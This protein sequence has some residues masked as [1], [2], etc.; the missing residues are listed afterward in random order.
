MDVQAIV[1]HAV[2]AVPRAREKNLVRKHGIGVSDEK[3]KEIEEFL[4]EVDGLS[5]LA[6]F[7]VDGID[8]ERA[9]F[10]HLDYRGGRALVG[11]RFF[12]ESPHAREQLI[13]VKGLVDIVVASGVESVHLSAACRYGRNDDD[14][15]ILVLP[16]DRLENLKAVDVAE[17]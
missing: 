3:K 17:I 14:G 2:L 1:V 4:P 7:H 15:K 8:L 16:S 9:A 12:Q 10:K 11:V 6:H 5:V 13:D